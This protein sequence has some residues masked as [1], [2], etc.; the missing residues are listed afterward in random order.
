MN[1]SEVLVTDNR[2]GTCPDCESNGERTKVT[3]VGRFYNCPGCGLGW[4]EQ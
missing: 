1:S 3:A 2:G 4:V